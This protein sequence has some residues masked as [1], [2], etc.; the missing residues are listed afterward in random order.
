MELNC[1]D[2]IPKMQQ[3]RVI[4]GMTLGAQ[5]ILW[6]FFGFFISKISFI[7]L[8]LILVFYFP[9]IHLEYLCLKLLASLGYWSFAC[10][11]RKVKKNEKDTSFSIRRSSA[12]LA[13]CGSMARHSRI[14]E[15]IFPVFIVLDSSIQYPLGKDLH[16]SRSVTSFW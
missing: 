16:N 1:V 15:I 4:W 12:K 11:E 14:L 3:L 2:W 10:R 7:H 6:E 5:L 13:I 9:F 8:E